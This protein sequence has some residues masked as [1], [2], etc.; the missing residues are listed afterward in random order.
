MAELLTIS[1]KIVLHIPLIGS[2]YT[3][4]NTKYVPVNP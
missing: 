1:T 4:V 2:K 3:S